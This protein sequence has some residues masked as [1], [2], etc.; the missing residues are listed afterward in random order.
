MEGCDH[1]HFKILGDVLVLI[2]TTPN[3]TP[4]VKLNVIIFRGLVFLIVS[5]KVDLSNSKENPSNFIPFP[6]STKGSTAK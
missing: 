2:K 3:Y 5:C 1:C 4:M 6:R